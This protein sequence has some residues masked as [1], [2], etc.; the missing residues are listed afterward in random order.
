MSRVLPR[1]ALWAGGIL[2]VILITSGWWIR[3]AL[4][5]VALKEKIEIYLSE[6]LQSDVTVG[7]LEGR[8]FPRIALS[9]SSVIVRQ[10]GRPGVPPL[11][12]LDTFTVAGSLSDLITRAR[13]RHVAE[14]R[15][16]GLLV[17]ISPDQDPGGQ[18]GSAGRKLD[19]IIID[20]F[21]APDTVLKLYSRNPLKPPREFLIH[22]LVMDSVGVNQTMPYIATLTN[23]LP[24]GEIEASGTLGPWNAAHPAQTPVKGTYLLSGA[25][26]DT[27]AGLAGVLSSAGKFAG[28]LDRIEVQGTT[29]TPNFQV[30]AGGK[31]VP[32]S[33]TFSA[34]VDGSDGDTYLNRVDGT[35]LNTQLVAT[36][37]IVGAA[38]VRGR[39]IQI[40]VTIDAGR[41]E[42]LLQLAV[43][44]EKPLLVG[45]AQLRANILIPADK[46]RKVIDKM[47]LRGEFGLTRATFTDPAVQGKLT[48]LSR[49]GQGKGSDEA[50][51]DVVSDL[52]GQLSLDRAVVRFTQLTFEVPGAVV[53][54]SGTYGLRSELLD[55]KGELRLR[56]PLSEA[57]G[58][59]VRGFFLK[60]FDPIFRKRGAGTVLPIKITGTRKDPKVGLDLF[61]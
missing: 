60:A 18:Y 44:T 51:G 59:G 20:R 35:F 24:K 1:V 36:G 3:H 50:M 49:H 56:A 61:N 2:A 9:G 27:I 55:F 52:R 11:L 31:A 33:T 4:S 37:K 30:D 38:D 16:R 57:A 8:L 14:V 6:E 34:V 23:P 46:S 47:T 53:R 25:N 43:D 13:P 42:D 21:E 32:L 39:D 40:D 48:G 26:L 5:T 15:L 19:R 41:I 28:P 29:E 7:T 22:H 17:Q 54:I 58:G 45:P 10:R 12:T